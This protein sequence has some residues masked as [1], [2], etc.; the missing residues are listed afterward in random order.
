MTQ[1]VD[2]KILAALIQGHDPPRPEEPVYT[3]GCWYVRLC[4]AVQGA[5]ERT[6]ALSGLFVGRPAGLRNRA[7]AKLLELPEEIG[8]ASLRTLGPA[9]GR[10]R[11]RHELNLLSIEA[12]AAAVHLQADV[13]LAAPSPR[14]ASALKAEGIHIEVIQSS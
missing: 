6:G 2:D 11:R 5:S 12:L 7:V 14:L 8:L 13:F 10:L 4:Q 1:L 3:T 9:I